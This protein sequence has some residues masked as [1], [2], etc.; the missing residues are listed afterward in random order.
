MRGHDQYSFPA[1]DDMCEKVRNQ[2]DIPI[3]PQEL[4]RLFGWDEFEERV[5]TQ[6]EVRNFLLRDLI[7]IL[8][9]CDGIVVLSGW[10]HSKGAIAEVALAQAIGLPVYNEHL[11]VIEVALRAEQWLEVADDE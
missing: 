6:Q 2:G 5:V 1:F 4:D 10:K 8:T 9:E 7:A 11:E 3:G